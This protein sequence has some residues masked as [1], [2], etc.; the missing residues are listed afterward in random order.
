MKIGLDLFVAPL[1][2]RMCGTDTIERRKGHAR[3]QR[4]QFIRLRDKG[5]AQIDGQKRGGCTAQDLV[6][7]K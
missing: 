5:I 1:F 7:C 2:K 3:H 4:N 6:Q